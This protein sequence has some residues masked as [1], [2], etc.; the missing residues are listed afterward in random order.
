MYCTWMIILHILNKTMAEQEQLF[1]RMIFHLLRLIKY[2]CYKVVLYSVALPP[3][4]NY[5]ALCH[6]RH[7]S[8]IF[9]MKQISTIISKTFKCVLIW[10]PV[11]YWI[12]FI[13]GVYTSFDNPQNSILFITLQ[14]WS[15]I[16]TI[17][18][19]EYKIFPAR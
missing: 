5:L 17:S 9:I 14:L 6:H 1:P 11:K 7:P 10:S 19:V 2:A 16:L 12:S 8:N 18:L 15:L 13:V 4:V 3:V